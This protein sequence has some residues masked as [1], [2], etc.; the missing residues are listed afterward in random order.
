MTK[1]CLIWIQDLNETLINL[2]LKSQRDFVQ[3]EPKIWMR[4]CL[5]WI[6]NF[7]ETSF[8]LNLKSRQNFVQ[9]LFKISLNLNKII[10]NFSSR[11]RWDRPCIFLLSIV[12]FV[13]ICN[14]CYLRLTIYNV[15]EI[16]F[17]EFVNQLLIIV[18]LIIKYIVQYKIIELL[19]EW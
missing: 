16:I 15:F 5:I 4:L 1:F 8:N 12:L 7:N 18:T 3:S 10:I 14:F 13:K 17:N 11:P 19:I 6:S 2:N 9:S